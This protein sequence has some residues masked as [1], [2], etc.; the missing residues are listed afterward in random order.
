MGHTLGG[1]PSQHGRCQRYRLQFL[2]SR[3]RNH[4]GRLYA[5]A[6][7]A[8]GLKP[9]PGSDNF[10]DVPSGSYY[11]EA[12]ADLINVGIILGDDRGCLNPL[13]SVTRAE[14]AVILHRAL[15]M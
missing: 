8:F 12:V 11:A 6:L 13:N 7:Q 2:R 1:V 9:A 14:M 5:D 15:T 3:L 4:Q 10:A